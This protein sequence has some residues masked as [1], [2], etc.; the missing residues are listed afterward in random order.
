MLFLREVL[1]FQP[2]AYKPGTKEAGMKWSE[3][4]NK[5]NGYPL[6]SS[7]PRDQRNVREH[8]AWLLSDHKKK[9]REEESASGISPDPPT[10]KEQILEEIVELMKS[11]LMHVTK[12]E[13]KEEQKRQIALD[14][15]DK[16]MKTWAKSIRNEG[17]DTE[18]EEESEKEVP[19]KRRKRRGSS[20]ALTYLAER[21]E[22]E[23][24]LRK[25][26]IALRREE[27]HLQAEQ[28]REQLKMQHDQLKLMTEILGKLAK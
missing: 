24:E 19:V 13:K 14:C 17:H 27:L 26:E 23:T 18:S 11:P 12:N 8:F 6:F 16:A 28:Q 9:C 1:F 10:E 2:F 3:V 7:V 20:D 22:R 15:R 25:Q 21:A 5:I 4:S